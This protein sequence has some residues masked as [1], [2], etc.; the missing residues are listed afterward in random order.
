MQL[1][2]DE[3]LALSDQAMEFR[4]VLKR[5]PAGG[6]ET[7]LLDAIRVARSAL[8]TVS[9]RALEQVGAALAKERSA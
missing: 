1:T 9:T 3:L 8:F 7:A 6:S 4:E 5:V 2:S